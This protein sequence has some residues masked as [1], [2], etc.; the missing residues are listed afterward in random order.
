MQVLY[1][2]ELRPDNANNIIYICLKYNPFLSAPQAK[3][4]IVDVRSIRYHIYVRTNQKLTYKGE[5][6]CATIQKR[7][8]TAKIVLIWRI[9]RLVI[10]QHVTRKKATNKQCAGNFCR[11]IFSACTNRNF[12]TSINAY[13]LNKGV[14]GDNWCWN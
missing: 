11:R 3:M 14:P 6:K 13:R 12:A 5:K 2:A 8:V 7:I 1:Q 4:H 10:S 9:Q